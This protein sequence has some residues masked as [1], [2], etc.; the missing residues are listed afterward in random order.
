MP[1]R[2]PSEFR[3]AVWKRLVAGG[4]VSSLRKELGVS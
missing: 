1:K 2:Y 4:K 3:R